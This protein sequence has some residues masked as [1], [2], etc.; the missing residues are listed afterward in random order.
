MNMSLK[1]IFFAIATMILVN[2][3]Y[4]QGIKV[5]TDKE[6]TQRQWKKMTKKITPEGFVFVKGGTYSTS[7]FDINPDKDT[8]VLISEACNPPSSRITVSSFIISKNE[9]TNKQYKDFVNWVKDS[10]ALTILAE[11]DS[12]FYKDA[13]LKTLDWS[14]RSIVLDT[15]MFSSLYPLYIK[16][17]IRKNGGYMLNTKQVKYKF[18]N[19]DGINYDNNIYPDTSVWYSDKIGWDDHFARAYFSDKIYESFPVVGVSWKQANA[20]C[21]WLTKNKLN[22]MD[23]YNQFLHYRLPSAAE[24]EYC[25]GFQNNKYKNKIYN[26]IN[27]INTVQTYELSLNDV[28][29][30]YLANFG[31]IIDKNNFMTKYGLFKS[32][33]VGS[34][35]MWGEGLYDIA[36][37]VSEWVLDPAPK[38][39]NLNR[40]NFWNLTRISKKIKLDKLDIT[41]KSEM[42]ISASDSFSAILKKMYTYLGFEDGYNLWLKMGSPMNEQEIYKKRDDLIIAEF[43][44]EEI[45]Y[46]IN[47]VNKIMHDLKVLNKLN[48]PKI[49]MG[50]SWHDGPA[51][52]MK[53]VKQVYSEN[54]SHSTIGFRVCAGIRFDQNIKIKN[55]S[56]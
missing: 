43:D 28:N 40:L 4:A 42:F 21:N 22:N 11:K 19:E 8:S 20:Y 12:E 47:M 5:S 34:Y 6:V 24:F 25:Q 36:G 2:S 32:V 27:I 44:N 14:K 10:I 45:I 33:K 23:D 18:I 35:P 7:N 38:D 48:Q 55:S 9:V 37:N 53:G 26:G 13:L 15:N 52:M 41:T 1:K 31:P 29:G 49:V 17:D 3:I 30:K 56:K 39:I 50:G 46:L 51:Y 16:N 54:E